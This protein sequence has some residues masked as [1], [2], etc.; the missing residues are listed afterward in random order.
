MTRL[1]PLGLLLLGTACATA[2]RDPTT[3][4]EAYAKALEENRLQDAYRLTTGGPDGEVAF[5]DEYSD[6]PART[7]RA[8]AVRSGA[9]MLE[10]RAP[11]VTLARQGEDWRVVES[12]AADV[13][14]AA[15]K[16]FLD[17][18]DARDWKGA[19][20]LLASPLRAR[21]TPERLREDFEREPLSKERL[22]R[23]RLALNT[24]VRV[25]AGEALFP[26]GEE[27]AVRLLL[28]DGEYRVAAIE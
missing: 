21:Y 27:R 14:R 11:S 3:V 15:L 5:L 8:A 6:A 1:A 9:A 22:R 16:K 20:G 19:W 17:A 10:A 2:S 28:E 23:A 4:A 18:V 24:R 13:P 7:E 26:L 12:R 25:A